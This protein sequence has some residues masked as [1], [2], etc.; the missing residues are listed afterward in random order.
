M[1]SPPAVA[2]ALSKVVVSPVL[3]QKE[4]HALEKVEGWCL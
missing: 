2:L 1:P 4:P 3:P